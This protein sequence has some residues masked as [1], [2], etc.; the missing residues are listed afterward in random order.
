[1]TIDG[2]PVNQTVARMIRLLL[3]N[4]AEIH[5]LGQGYLL[6]PYSREQ[7]KIKLLESKHVLYEVARE[8]GK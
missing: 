2:Q 6:I 8:G 5:R 1:M 4:Q 3:Q 7:A